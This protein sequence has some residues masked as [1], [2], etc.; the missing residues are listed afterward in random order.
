MRP[1]LAKHKP[2]PKKGTKK[3]AQF[4]PKIKKYRSFKPVQGN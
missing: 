2:K 1:E 4:T 3:E